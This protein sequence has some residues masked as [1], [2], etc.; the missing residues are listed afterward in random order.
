MNRVIANTRDVDLDWDASD[1]SDPGND[2]D[3]I[4]DCSVPC[5]CRFGALGV[6]LVELMVKEHLLKRGKDHSCAG[7]SR[8]TKLV[9]PMMVVISP[10]AEDEVGRRAELQQLKSD[11]FGV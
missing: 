9:V 6:W 2:L 7:L 10:V 3:A 4:R 11:L 5:I 8:I 1:F